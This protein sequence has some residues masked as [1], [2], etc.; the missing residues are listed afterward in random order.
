VT[1]PALYVR[2][3][4]CRISLFG[5]H[6]VQQDGVV[7]VVDSPLH[8]SSRKARGAYPGPCSFAF[9]PSTSLRMSP[10]SCGAHAERSRSTGAG[11]GPDICLRKFRDDRSVLGD[12]SRPITSVYAMTNHDHTG[13]WPTI[14]DLP[15]KW[16][17]LGA[18]LVTVSVSRA[19]APRCSAF[20]RRRVFSGGRGACPSDMLNR[21][22]TKQ[23]N[24]RPEST[25]D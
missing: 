11:W 13:L 19:W 10:L 1:W 3:R 17:R 14:P 18:V 21:C 12:D 2:P 6:W 7:W 25:E 24:S 23:A 5:R 16:G 8:A 9:H 4:R 15:R 22:L 20:N